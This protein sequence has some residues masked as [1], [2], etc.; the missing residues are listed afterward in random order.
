MIKPQHG[1]HPALSAPLT[2]SPPRRRRLLSADSMEHEL[3]D[4]S[5]FLESNPLLKFSHPL[6]EELERL[7]LQDPPPPGV[8]TPRRPPGGACWGPDPPTPARPRLG[9][10]GQEEMTTLSWQPS[11]EVTTPCTTPCTTPRPPAPRG[12]PPAPGPDPVLTQITR[13]AGQIGIG[14]TISYLQSMTRSVLYYSRATPDS[15]ATP[16]LLVPPLSSVSIACV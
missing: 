14:E 2:C 6:Q 11:R 1:S 8:P 12:D 5:Q 13:L 16:E 7:F 4:F 15:R 9:S 3:E 10:D